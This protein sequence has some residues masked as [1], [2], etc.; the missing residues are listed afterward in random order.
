[1][2]SATLAAPPGR[3]SA[4]RVRTTGTGASGEI[5]AVSPNQYSSSI[6]SPATSTRT[7]EK[8]GIVN[9]TGGSSL[10]ADLRTFYSVATCAA[11]GLSPKK[12]GPPR[13]VEADQRRTD[14]PLSAGE[15]PSAADA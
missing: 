15:R 4:E 6:A 7:R 5:R 14:E 9:V 11:P 1:M 2:F 3:C 13:F 10:R 8:S 12:K